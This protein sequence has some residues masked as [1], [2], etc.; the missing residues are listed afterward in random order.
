MG[1]IRKTISRFLS[2]YNIYGKNITILAGSVI[3][4]GKGN[5]ISV[6]LIEL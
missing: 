6:E 2:D 1:K 3:H 5:V 4:D